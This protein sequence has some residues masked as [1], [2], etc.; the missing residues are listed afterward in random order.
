MENFNLMDWLRKQKNRILLVVVAG[1]VI[2]TFVGFGLYIGQGGG[3]NTVAEVNDDKIP[4]SHFTSLYNRVVNNHRD[5]KEELTPEVLSQIKQDVMQSLIQESVFVQESKRYGIQVS[6]TELAGSLA[7]IPAFQKDGK[8]DA[9]TY[10]QALHYGLHSTP[11]EFEETQRKQI[12][13]NR[14]RSFVLQGIKISDKELEMEFGQ[15][16]QTIQGK[17]REKEIKEFKEN[18]EKFREKVRQEKAAHVLN[19]WYQQLGTNLKVKV[20]LDEIENRMRR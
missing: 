10:V 13:I 1:F 15:Y 7:S 17:E 12:A 11:E 19:R 20:Y 3:K 5:K 18:P 16:I 2:S 8:F 9:Q 14:L 6:D 4:Y